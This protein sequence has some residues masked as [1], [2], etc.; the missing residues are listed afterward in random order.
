MIKAGALFYAIVLS[1]VIAIMTSSVMLFGYASRSSSDL[2]KAEL[3][4]LENAESGIQLLKSGELKLQFGEKTKVDLFGEETDSVELLVRSWGGFR[5]ASSTAFFRSTSYKI[6]ALIGT[7]SDTGSVSLYLTDKDKPLA[8][9]GRTVINGSAMLPKAGIKR[10]YIE[11]QNFVG[12]EFVHG[13]ISQSAR[14]LPEFDRSL[15]KEIEALLAGHQFSVDDSILDVSGSLEATIENNFDNKTILIRSPG[16]FLIGPGKLKGNIGIVSSGT[17]IVGNDVVLEDVIL[18]A[19]K[20]LFK[21]GVHGSFQAFASDSIILE[22]DVV[23]DYPSVLGLVQTKVMKSGILISK[24]DSVSGTVFSIRKDDLTASSCIRLN[25]ESFIYG[26]VYTN[27]WAD[28]Q[29]TI[30]GSLYCDAIQLK[31]PSSVYEN[32]L[33][34]AVIDGVK[35][36]SHYTGVALEDRSRGTEIVKYLK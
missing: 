3:R 18:V 12:S 17:M 10:A 14:K 20:I 16:N 9:C 34:N 21:K 15:K 11:G 32:H 33:L 31:T 25:K 5:L 22:E 4:V 23:L 13:Q 36:S 7:R 2:H 24:N 28:V 30:Y 26:Q 1:L 29:G 6:T 19:P 27:G 8:V 35:L